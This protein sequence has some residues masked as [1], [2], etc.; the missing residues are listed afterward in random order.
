MAE[1]PR[2]RA[3]SDLDELR[4]AI[5]VG[6]GERPARRYEPPGRTTER[7]RLSFMSASEAYTVRG[8][9]FAPFGRRVLGAVLDLLAVALIWFMGFAGVAALAVPIYVALP[10]GSPTY[11]APVFFAFIASIPFWT[12]WVFNSQGWSPAGK[13][14]RLRAVDEFGA[15]PGARVGLVRTLAMIPSILP[16]GLGFWAAAWDD[17]GQ[18]WHDRIAGTRVIELLR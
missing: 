1:S 15:P 12:L 14:T 10:D 11:L 7:S 9:R 17:E 2:N 6:V 4:A 5:A 16:L 8:E 18:T 13:L 3:L